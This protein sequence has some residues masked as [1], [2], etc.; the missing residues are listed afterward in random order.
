MTSLRTSPLLT[1]AADQ[2]LGSATLRAEL[3]REGYRLD[4]RPD[5][6]PRVYGPRDVAEGLDGVPR[7]GSYCVAR[8]VG[9]ERA[10]DDATADTLRPPP[11]GAE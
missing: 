1:L 6:H 3:A 2:V 5:G 9:R 10:R 8:L 7:V 11:P 4:A